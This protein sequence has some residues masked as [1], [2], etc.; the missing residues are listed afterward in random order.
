MEVMDTSRNFQLKM[1]YRDSK[2][3]TIGEGTTEIQ[4][5]YC[6]KYLKIICTTTNNKR[7]LQSIL[8]KGGFRIC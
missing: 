1:F 3:C 6:K 7:Y 4:K 2:L 5:L 8:T